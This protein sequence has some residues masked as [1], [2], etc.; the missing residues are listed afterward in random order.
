VPTLI[1]RPVAT[2]W[3]RLLSFV[4]SLTVVLLAVAP[5]LATSISTDLWVYQQGDTVNV[6]G[7][8][9]DPSENVEIVTTDPNAIEV[10]R[11]T[12]LSDANGNIAYSFLLNS[13]VPGIYDVVATGLSSGLSASTQFDPTVNLQLAGSDTAQHP[14]SPGQNLPDVPKGTA[15]AFNASANA[16]SVADGSSV[17][18]AVAQVSGSAAAVLSGAS[19]T[20]TN[21]PGGGPGNGCCTGA[22]A[23]V[24][25]SVATGSLT[26]G[27]NYIVRLQMTGTSSVGDTVTA[28]DL[29]FNFTVVAPAVTDTQG[30]SVTIN[31]TSPN[32]GVPNGLNGW[33][34]SAPVSGTVDASDTATGGSGI[35]AINCTDSLSGITLGALSASGT[36]GSRTISVAGEGVHSISCTATDAATNTT[37]PA[38]SASVSID[39]IDPIVSVAAARPAD[40]GTWYN[41]PVSFNTS[42]TDGITGSGVSDANCTADQ[43]YTGPDGSALTVNGSCTDNAGNVGNGSS[44][45]FNFDDTNPT[46]VHFTNGGLVDDGSYYFGFDP[47]G[48]TTCSAD[49]APSP[50]QSGF[51]LCTVTPPVG[52]KHATGGHQY[53][54]TAYDVAGNSD[55]ATLS[56][57]ILAW[58]LKGFYQPVDMNMVNT[59]K[60]GS[61]VPLKF[62]VFA[63][64]TT[65]LTS[66]DV[67]QS[68]VQQQITCGDYLLEDAIEITSTGGT[69]LRYDSTSG[70][71]IQ[72]WQTPKNKVG[73][74]WVVTL[75]TDD[76]S[77]LTASFKLK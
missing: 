39:T 26:I 13:D 24:G 27:A 42:G 33:F 8:G 73:S 16:P 62:E 14:N 36:T 41:A 7:D 48:P 22:D 75:T 46:N 9:F 60:G 10:D 30:P 52:D 59:V 35:S 54:A 17:T 37:N 45:S 4:L 1:L 53:L 19:G 11:G 20:F 51:D 5:V 25:V 15:V 47:A 66:T 32:S 23:T 65:E 6:S 38:V 64:I 18:W 12:V 34:I 21:P 77:T 70:Q 49:D 40:F 2:V 55:T 57:T 69:V 58:N 31:F 74:C 61:T 72:N 43:N 68:F 3:T 29:F 44:A 71:F 56:Y 50:P 28:Q 63:G 76:G 67:V